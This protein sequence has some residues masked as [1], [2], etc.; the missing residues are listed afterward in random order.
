MPGQLRLRRAAGALWL[1]AAGPCRLA[2]GVR[3]SSAHLG[4]E[5]FQE[6]TKPQRNTSTQSASSVVAEFDIKIPRAH[7]KPNDTTTAG[8]TPLTST[9]GT[10][11][12]GTTTAGT[13][14]PPTTTEEAEVAAYEDEDTDTVS[15]PD[16]TA[17][18]QPAGAAEAVEDNGQPL[19]P[20]DPASESTA[21]SGTRDVPE[22][23][24]ADLPKAADTP[25]ASGP[26]AGTPASSAPDAPEAGAP[27]L[28]DCNVG[29][30]H[31]PG[32]VLGKLRDCT[33]ALDKAAHA[34]KDQHGRSRDANQHYVETLGQ[35]AERLE[36]IRDMTELDAAFSSD[37]GKALKVLMAEADKVQ[38]TVQSM[39][40]AAGS[41]AA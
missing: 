29:G 39:T 31:T 11:T 30:E 21:G 28:V 15:N 4:L 36:G 12:A 6:S 23:E 32:E 34:V 19:S 14:R 5:A 33:H 2:L 37:Q 9:A 40:P 17:E 35:V 38:A 13:T 22:T 27:Q 24:A 25:S 1:L 41:A 10:T 20:A 18:K 16:P 26:P 7:H 8:T 3:D